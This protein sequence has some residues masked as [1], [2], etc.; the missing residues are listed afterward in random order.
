MFSYG[1]SQ[2]KTLCPMYPK[3]K[4]TTSKTFVDAVPDLD[5]HMAERHPETT[6]GQRV[7]TQ[8]GAK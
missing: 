2:T 5:A 6:W 4:W 3:C 7:L 8:K 1:R